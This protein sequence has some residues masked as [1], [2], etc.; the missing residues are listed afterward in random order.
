[1]IV[2]ED[3]DSLRVA[4]LEALAA[5]VVVGSSPAVE[6]ILTQYF[7]LAAIDPAPFNLYFICRRGSVEPQP[8]Q[9]DGQPLHRDTP[10]RRIA[11]AARQS[12]KLSMVH[13]I[14]SSTA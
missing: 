6:A 10:V 1:V 12:I 9:R 11:K 5:F 3:T 8:E 7:L 14:V 4:A 2:L 13:E